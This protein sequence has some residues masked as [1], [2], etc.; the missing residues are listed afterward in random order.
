ME[1]EIYTKFDEITA[2][3][4]AIYITH[5]LASIRF[6]DRA[7]VLKDGQLLD[8]GSHA[9]LMHKCPYYAELYNMQAQFYADSENMDGKN[10]E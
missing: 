8:I 7:V 1:A 6:C 9:E 10:E 5:R 2:D 4:T 3:K